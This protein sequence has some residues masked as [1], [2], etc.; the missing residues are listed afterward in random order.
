MKPLLSFVIPS[1]NEEENLPLL[2]KEIVNVLKKIGND[3]EIIFIDDGSTDKT[4]NVIVNLHQNDKKVIGIRHRGNFGKAIALVNGFT[5][6]R[7]DIIFTLDAD[8]Q[9]NPT[10]IP[11]FL[12]GFD[13]GYDIVI[14]WKRRRHDSLDKVISS[15]L[16]NE[17]VSLTTG[18]KYHDINCGFK[19]YHKN[20]VQNINFG[21]LF[22]LIPILA[23]KQNYKI[24]EI[25]VDHRPR[26]FGKSKFGFERSIQGGLDL[27]TVIF[28]TRFARRP[29]QFFGSLGLLCGFLGASIGAY[30][31]YLW[32]TTGGI[33]YRY[34]LLFLG[35]LLMIVGVQF[36]ST[37]LLAEMTIN[38]NTNQQQSANLCIRETIS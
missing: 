27:I 35:V 25:P 26:K 24:K 3:Y 1:K 20:V 28:L 8:L 22:R 10:E 5:K 31:T 15:R 21:E 19:A 7:G 34:P 9:D 14:G 12:T 30:I 29:A 6:A 16:F 33:G 37:G 38:L 11:N 17:V 36:I 23:A 32:A 2:Y 18:T 4:W 13:E